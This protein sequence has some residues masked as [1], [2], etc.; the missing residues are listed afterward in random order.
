MVQI[1]LF[2]V[3]FPNQENN[4]YFRI[5]YVLCVVIT[6]LRKWFVLHRISYIK[7][8]LK[9][10][11]KSMVIGKRRKKQT[12]RQKNATFMY[13]D[14]YLRHY[15]PSFLSL[16][17]LFCIFVK[18]LIDISHVRR[19]ITSKKL[20]CL[21]ICSP[22]FA[23]VFRAKILKYLIGAGDVLSASTPSNNLQKDDNN[24]RI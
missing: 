20:K 15:Y 23:C 10:C 22:F 16:F 19:K 24:R 9:Y 4:F 11:L 12:R 14:K 17:F 13:V 1:L 18:S 5:P 8:I 3:R 21:P 6:S 2:G 7:S